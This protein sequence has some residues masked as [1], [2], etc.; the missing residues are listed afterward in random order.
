MDPTLNPN[1]NQ[2]VVNELQE[3]PDIDRQSIILIRN[4][5]DFARDNLIRRYQGFVYN[6]TRPYFLMGADREDLAQEGM[7]GLVQAI[8]SYDLSK[9]V[10]FKTFAD[11]CV[12]RRICTAVKTYGRHKHSPL[13]SSFSLNQPSY[14]DEDDRETI[15]TINTGIVQDPIETITTRETFKMVEQKLKKILSPFEQNVYYLQLY[16]GLSYEQIAVRLNSHT[17]AVDNA[18]QRIRKKI[19]KHINIDD[20]KEI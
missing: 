20:E 11:V 1:L 6:K 14:G 4:G 7:L 3:E 16:E 10:P 15:E 9:D 12:T 5:D 17:K 13:N 18:I 8:K 19:S 2:D